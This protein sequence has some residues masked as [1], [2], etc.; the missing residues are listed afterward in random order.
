MTAA[1]FTSFLAGMIFGGGGT[2]LVMIC[3]MI[4]NQWYMAKMYSQGT[5]H[6]RAAARP[7]YLAGEEVD[8]ADFWKQEFPREEE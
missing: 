5:D 8:E 1:E 7:K 3:V 4:A 6:G 2:G